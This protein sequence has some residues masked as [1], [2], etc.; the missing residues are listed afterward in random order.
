MD[1]YWWSWEIRP[2]WTGSKC[3]CR[4][5]CTSQGKTIVDGNLLNKE[6]ASYFVAL[7]NQKLADNQGYFKRFHYKKF[8]KI[9]FIDQKDIDKF[10]PQN[11]IFK[12]W[13]VVNCCTRE[14]CWCKCIETIDE[15]LVIGQG[16]LDKKLAIYICKLHNHYLKFNIYKGSVA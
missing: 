10:L 14:K 9:K 15:D 3:W 8:S 1:I 6:L 11:T 13:K 2:C 7:H 5:I 4:K 12:R 16:T